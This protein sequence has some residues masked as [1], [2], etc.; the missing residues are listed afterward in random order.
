MKSAGNFLV[1]KMIA[2]KVLGMKQKL[3]YSRYS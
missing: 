3:N 2:Q 1:Q